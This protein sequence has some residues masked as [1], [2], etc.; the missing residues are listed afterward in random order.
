MVQC[1]TENVIDHER[2]HCLSVEAVANFR[3]CPWCELLK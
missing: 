1:R 2:L 3:A